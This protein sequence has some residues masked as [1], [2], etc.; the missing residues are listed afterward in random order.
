M[1]KPMCNAV[2]HGLCITSYGAI[3]PCCTSADFVH[4]DEVDDIRDYFYNGKKLQEAREVE[5]SE[6]WLSECVSCKNRS[7]KG[8]VSRK[9]KMTSWYPFADESFTK[10]NPF[11]IIH[12]DIS[13]GNTCNQQCIMCNSRFSSKWLKDDLSMIVEAPYIRRWKD[14]NIIRN[15]SLSYKHLDQIIDLV[16]ENTQKIEIKGGEPLYD[17]RFLYFVEKVIEKNPNVRFS[18]NT[19]GTYF[20]QKNIDMLNKI[21]NINIDVSIDGTGKVYEWIR[22]WKWDDAVE[23]FHHCMKELK[24]DPNLNYTTMVYNVDHIETFYNWAASVSHQY[25]KGIICNFTQV[26]TTPK[27][28]SVEYASKDRLKNGLTQIEK[29]IQ[30][31]EKICSHSPIFKPRLEIL[32]NFIK[33]CYDKE[34]NSDFFQD[35][36]NTHEYMVKIRGWD[37]RDYVNM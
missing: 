1:A 34:V 33:T 27:F 32:Y 11:E 4:I 21:K 5:F 36:I 28:L 13:F 12:M 25:G 19:N 16:S 3:N 18:T 7:D 2:H 10:N 22:N 8:L 15:W 37:L 26:V 6:N 20:N 29:I 35:F 30:D 9:D 31:P 24:H 23:N 17:K 14:D